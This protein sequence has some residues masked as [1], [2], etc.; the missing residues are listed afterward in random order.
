M[1]APKRPRA[2]FFG[3]QADLGALLDAAYEAYGKGSDV[4]GKRPKRAFFEAV[5]AGL[6][7]ASSPEREA[8]RGQFNLDTLTSRSGSWGDGTRVTIE[9]GKKK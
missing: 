1:D 3:S 5:I 7:P 8:E 9:K 6:Y 2:P 4:Y